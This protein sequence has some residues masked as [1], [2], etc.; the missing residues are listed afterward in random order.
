ML[1]A[2]MN[3]HVQVTLGEPLASFVDNEVESG[4]FG[5]AQEVVEA[6]LRL[7]EEEQVKLEKLR[8]LLIEGEQSGEPRYVDREEFLARMREKYAR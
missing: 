2:V 6:G 7:L 5:S 4:R 8:E 1:G 3:K